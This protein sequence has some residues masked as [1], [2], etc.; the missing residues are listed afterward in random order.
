MSV[1][2]SLH[3]PA[4]AT[5]DREGFPLGGSQPTESMPQTPIWFRQST[6][7]EGLLEPVGCQV[8]GHWLSRMPSLL[9]V[10]ENRHLTDAGVS[11]SEPGECLQCRCRG[12]HH[13][14]PSKFVVLG[15][16]PDFAATEI[17]VTP[18]KSENRIQSPAGGP[19]NDD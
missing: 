18:L 8:P 13:P 19:S 12:R 6:Q 7:V 14:S 9:G 10:R 3:P 5:L 16:P 2:M 4:A 15:P 1:V 17:E 11:Y